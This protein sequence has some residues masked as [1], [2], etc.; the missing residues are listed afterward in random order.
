MPRCT[1]CNGSGLIKQSATKLC[2]HCGGTVCYLCEQ[3][4]RNGMYEECPTCF[5]SGTIQQK[6][7]CIKNPVTKH[8]V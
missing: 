5:A 6:K 7:T 3:S 1:R 4:R 2:L 8:N